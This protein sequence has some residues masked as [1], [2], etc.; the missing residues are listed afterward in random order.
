M[1]YTTH[2]YVDNGKTPC[3]WAKKKGKK[4]VYG[5][6]DVPV[7]YVLPMNVRADHEQRHSISDILTLLYE[8][9]FGQREV[10]PQ[11]KDKFIDRPAK[12]F[13]SE[14]YH[15]SLTARRDN[16][17]MI[18]S[19][20]NY[21]HMHRWDVESAIAAPLYD[22]YRVVQANLA[23]WLQEAGE[24]LREHVCTEDFEP[25][26]DVIAS[27]TMVKNIAAIIT[28]DDDAAIA[29]IEG[30]FT[31]AS[32]R[33]HSATDKDI[34]NKKLRK[35][36]DENKKD[37]LDIPTTP[38]KFYSRENIRRLIKIGRNISSIWYVL[39]GSDDIVDLLEFEP[40]K[41]QKFIA[42][43]DSGN[44]KKTSKK[45]EALDTGVHWNGV[46][47]LAISPEDEDAWN[48]AASKLEGGV[49]TRVDFLDAFST[50]SDEEV[51]DD[52]DNAETSPQAKRGKSRIR[53]S[54]VDPQ[55]F[56]DQAQAEAEEARKLLEEKE[57]ALAERRKAAAARALERKIEEDQ[58]AEK[59]KKKRRTR[60]GG[61]RNRARREAYSAKH[62][63]EQPALDLEENPDD[64]V[65]FDSLVAE[66]GGE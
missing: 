2:G 41:Y 7:A 12:T 60:R 62:Q 6:K 30:I 15:I 54:Y 37:I 53:I 36:I 64:I 26:W 43:S 63:A 18:A 17:V 39:E 25:E 55:V 20:A 24:G 13:F 65:D 61:K 38:D 16:A 48:R 27:D 11:Y 28:G 51:E 32:W 44:P 22:D 49:K 58:A 3:A 8:I 45:K 9:S 19:M 21:Y 40:A 1:P 35:F 46:V 59:K 66:D 33:D 31:A 57:A 52:E 42:D 4:V 14:R 34:S 23:R 47:P 10:T 50:N 56:K 5:I 29:F